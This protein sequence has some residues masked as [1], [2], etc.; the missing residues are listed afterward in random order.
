M[1]LQTTIGAAFRQ[2]STSLGEEAAFQYLRRL[3]SQDEIGREKTK[4]GLKAAL[5]THY[6]ARYDVFLKYI[7]HTEFRDIRFLAEGKNGKVFSAVWNP[8]LSIEN[9]AQDLQ[10]VLKYIS[11]DSSE[12]RNTF[13]KF[14][15]E[16]VATTSRYSRFN[17]RWKS[18]IQP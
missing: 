1:L 6:N 9:P 13:T 2:I 11:N 5:G 7:D 16:V 8:P 15:Q 17:C 12:T 3:A 18:C 4:D 14:L 10:V